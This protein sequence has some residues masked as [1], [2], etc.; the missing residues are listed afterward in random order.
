MSLRIKSVLLLH[1]CFRDPCELQNRFHAS[2]AGAKMMLLKKNKSLGC[3]IRGGMSAL[4]IERVLVLAKET[5]LTLL[6]VRYV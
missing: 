2:S 4:N 1:E 6:M 5:V 3:S